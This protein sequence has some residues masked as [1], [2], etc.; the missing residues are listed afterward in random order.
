M[1]NKSRRPASFVAGANSV[2]LFGLFVFVDEQC[3]SPREDCIGVGRDCFYVDLFSTIYRRP[4]LFSDISP[5]SQ[6]LL[7]HIPGRGP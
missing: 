6:L 1:P 2:L 7:V 3:R 5:C 4:I